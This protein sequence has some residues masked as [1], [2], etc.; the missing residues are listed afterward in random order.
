MSLYSSSNTCIAFQKAR[1]RDGGHGCIQWVVR[2][3]REG[4][5]ERRRRRFFSRHA[6]LEN[7][8]LL[9]FLVTVEPLPK[10]EEALVDIFA[11]VSAFW[12]QISSSERWLERTGVKTLKRSSGGWWLDLHK[13]TTTCPNWNDNNSG[14]SGFL[15]MSLKIFAAEESLFPGVGGTLHTHVERGQKSFLL[16]NCVSLCFADVFVGSENALEDRGIQCNIIM[17]GRGY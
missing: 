5:K 6:H 17:D 4:A 16:Q 2:L 9:S 12:I 14:H 10:E 15:D 11:I 7:C 3:T 13:S 8:E 1:D